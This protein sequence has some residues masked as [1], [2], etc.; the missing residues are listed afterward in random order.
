MCVYV[1][2]YLYCSYDMTFF[3]TTFPVPKM[4]YGVL[5]FANK[6]FKHLGW[7][8]ESH[9]VWSFSFS[10]FQLLSEEVCAVP[11]R[12]YSNKLLK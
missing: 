6:N 3:C 10:I 12:K 11:R 5:K 1:Q 4:T 7:D 9:S 8:A 2:V